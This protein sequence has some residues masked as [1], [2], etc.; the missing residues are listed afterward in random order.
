MNRRR[1][2]GLALASLWLAM[3][4]CDTGGPGP[5]AAAT[6]NALNVYVA[7]TLTAKAN[8]TATAP[9]STPGPISSPTPEET[10]PAAPSEPP[11][12]AAPSPA[13]SQAPA[14]PNG[15]VVHAAPAA[16]AP[17]IDGD[18]SDWPALP[19]QA[20][21]PTYKPENWG[22]PQDNSFTFGLA[23]D[24]SYLYVAAA[25]VDDVHVQTQH[26]EL[27]YKG[28]SLEVLF[29]SDLEGDF[30]VPH[31][32]GDDYQL[33][34][35]PGAF[36]GDS[37][38]AWLWFPASRSGAA[39]GVRLAAKPAGQG[40]TLEAAIPWAL[41]N[42]S[43]AGGSRFGFVMSSSDNDTPGTA[44]QKGMVS[45]VGTRKLLDPTSWGTL[46]LDP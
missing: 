6:V 39:N 45:N 17:L 42:V 11:S 34:L 14:R 31:L 22:G 26:N 2:A 20:T 40:Y 27:I 32:D 21:I 44:Q 25:V 16:T 12:A 38:E 10:Q 18:L 4:A 28:D 33:G 36:N 1:A 24:A 7:Q 35:S 9:E 37:P 13:V 8:L 3:L 29:D 46:A 15:D 5:D 19:Y 41:F 30:D 43:P 23:W